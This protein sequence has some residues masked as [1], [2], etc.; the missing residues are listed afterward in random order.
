MSFGREKPKYPFLLDGHFLARWICFLR[1]W[2]RALQ[3]ARGR[4]CSKPGAEPIR[5]KFFCQERGRGMRRLSSRAERPFEPLEK[6]F[7]F[8]SVLKPI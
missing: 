3:F 2:S 6:G 1:V 5:W 8:V 4:Q 7:I